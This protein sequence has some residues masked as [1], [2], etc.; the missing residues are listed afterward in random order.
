MQYKEYKLTNVGLQHSQYYQG[1]GTLPEQYWQTVFVGWGESPFSAAEDA[2]EQALEQGW[3]VMDVEN[4]LSSASPELDE[5]WD[6]QA[7][8]EEMIEFPQYVVE[9]YLR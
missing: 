2:L 5:L 1:A 7:E 4:L 8:N 3:E 6:R 9:L